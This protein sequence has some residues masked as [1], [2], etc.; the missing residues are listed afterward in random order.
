MNTGKILIVSNKED[1]HVDNVLAKIIDLGGQPIRLNT[2]DI[3]KSVFMDILISDD[4]TRDAVEIVEGNRSVS[5]SEIKSIWWRRP[6][7]FTFPNDF[8]EVQKNFA[9]KETSDA[10]MGILNSSG[11]FWVSHPQRLNEASR[12][13]EQLTRARRFGFK[14]PE[15]LVT[16]KAENVLRFCNDHEQVVYKVMT[17]P[18]LAAPQIVEPVAEEDI[19]PFKAVKTT[20]VTEQVLEHVDSVR[21]TPC[22]FQKYIP[23]AFELRI[24]VIGSQVFVAKIDSQSREETKIDWRNYDVEI[25]YS[26]FDIP[27]DLAQQ[28]LRFVE[29][30]QLSFSALDFIVTPDNEYIFIENNPNGQFIWVENLVPEL[31]MTEHL[32]KCLISG[33]KL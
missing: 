13:V 16:T 21:Y 14:I 5:I 26:K 3:P 28:I 17:D 8:S 31:K 27:I 12:K 1:F 25:P 4:K 10:L 9:Q 2:E 6:Q 15:T 22:L 20:W 23:K 33:N 19:Q 32:A 7:P 30:Y 11:C 29:S 18:F 24:T